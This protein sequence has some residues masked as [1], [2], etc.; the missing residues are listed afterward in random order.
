MKDLNSKE[1]LVSVIIPIFNSEKFLKESIESVLNQTY[2]N[3]EIIAVDDGSSD[4][5]LKIL[6]QY[7]NKITIVSQT[8][9]GLAHALNAGIKKM[10][11]K[12]FKWFSPDDI[13]IPK[14]IEILVQEA[15]KLPENTIVYS[16]WE[17]IDEK[18][19][20]LRDF[21][22]S[23]YNELDNFNFNIR[24]LDGQQI[25]VNTTLI[26]TTLFT[27]GCTIHKLKDPVA[28]DY[29]FFLRA[30]LLYNLN[31]FLISKSLLKYRINKNQLSH[32]NITKTLEYLKEIRTEILSQL[33]EAKHKEYLNALEKYKGKKPIS[34]KT[35]EF[36]LKFLVNALPEK[37]TEKLIVFYLNTIRRGR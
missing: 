23:N 16:N 18:G 25:N 29:D 8:N 15:S 36:G 27:K 19:N 4:N 22:E 30:G 2:K 5:S 24:L 7:S 35:M 34:K 9:Q 11:G 13:L 21:S 32:K 14:A 3:I 37:A 12:W 26:P 28:I 31:F 1:D 10:I 17:L 6:K 33:P 20:K